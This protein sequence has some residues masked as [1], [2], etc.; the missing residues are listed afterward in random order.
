M[1]YSFGARKIVV[2]GLGPMGCI[3][4]IRASDESGSCSAPVS[5]VAAAH[6]DAVQGALSQLEQFLPRLTIVHAQFYDFLLERME[7][8]SKYG[9]QFLQLVPP[10]PL[11]LLHNLIRTH[12]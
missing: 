10:L 4:A 6:N 2:A 11:T 3:P 12:T 8:P 5:A 1:L 7:N 9:K